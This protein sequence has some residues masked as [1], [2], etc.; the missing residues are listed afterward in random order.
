MWLLQGNLL[1]KHD[2]WAAPALHLLLKQQ[3]CHGG[4]CVLG[5]KLRLS[6]RHGDGSCSQ[7]RLTSLRRSPLGLRFGLGR[8]FRTLWRALR[9]LSRL[10]WLH[11]LTLRLLWL[12]LRI[13]VPPS[14]SLAVV[15]AAP[16]A[17]FSSGGGLLIVR[18]ILISIFLVCWRAARTSTN[19]A[20]LLPSRQNR[21]YRFGLRFRW[22]WSRWLCCS[23]TCRL[24]ID[25]D[26]SGRHSAKHVPH[27]CR[28]WG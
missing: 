4:L 27:A 12:W 19:E 14:T 20:R 18:C 15:S 25:V 8:A 22:D 6:V 23:D 24:G 2:G 17:C 1:M 16:S 10:L 28:A 11:W 13:G 21:W 3:L 9:R 7:N 26:A 5:T